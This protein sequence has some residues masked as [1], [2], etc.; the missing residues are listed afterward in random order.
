MLASVGGKEKE[1]LSWCLVVA[2][3]HKLLLLLLLLA[4]SRLFSKC[5]MFLLALSP[6]DLFQTLFA[7]N[8]LMIWML[9]KFAGVIFAITLK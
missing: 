4:C 3:T 7:L 8:L 6:I 5:Q 1:G 2:T 9:T